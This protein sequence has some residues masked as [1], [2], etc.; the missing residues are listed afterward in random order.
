M[1][2]ICYNR[3]WEAL[4]ALCQ[5]GQALLNVVSLAFSYER[6]EREMDGL[7]GTE[8]KAQVVHTASLLHA[9]CIASLKCEATIVGK[10]LD[11]FGGMTETEMREL[12]SVDDQSALVLYWLQDLLASRLASGGLDIRNPPVVAQVW[13][14]LVNYVN[15]YAIAKKI[16][17]FPLPLPLHQSLA[18][19]D[20]FVAF[21]SPFVISAFVPSITVCLLIVFA[22]SAAYHGIFIVNAAL[23]QPFGTKSCHLPLAMLHR[24][25]IKGML[26]LVTQKVAEKIVKL[27]EDEHE[28]AASEEPSDFVFPAVDRHYI[29]EAM[30]KRKPHKFTHSGSG[31]LTQVSM[32]SHTDPHTTKH[33]TPGVL[34]LNHCV[35][36]GFSPIPT[37]LVPL[38][39]IKHPAFNKLPSQPKSDKNLYSRT[40]LNKT[41]TEAEVE[42]TNTQQKV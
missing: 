33:H 16:A 17:Q 4:S 10:P 21:L 25:V 37:D 2:S 7:T 1:T 5:M 35:A 26:S 22:T 32:F 27:G 24:Q 38:P 15:A 29:Y 30:H 36:T 6:T 3:Y 8:W 23:Q 20:I 34:T 19:S 39:S 18:F 41:E 11:V 28:A 9:T 14:S 13:T 12:N 40:E 42:A 31:V